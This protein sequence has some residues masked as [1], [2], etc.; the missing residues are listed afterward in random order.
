MHRKKVLLVVMA[1]A[2]LFLLASC[3]N[4]ENVQRVNYALRVAEEG[5]VKEGYLNVEFT[6]IDEE[7]YQVKLDF[8]LGEESFSSTS[9]VKADDIQGSLF[10]LML[11]NPSIAQT[12]GVLSA[13]Q[14]FL[15]PAFLGG[16][17]LSE[18]FEWKQKDEEGETEIIV[19]A[20]ETRFGKEAL[21]VE[22]RKDGKLVA[23]IL[24]EKETSFPLVVDFQD[25]EQL[26]SGQNR[27]YIEAEEV[28]WR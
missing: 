20:S 14:V 23:R 5:G 18:G 7:N 2:M 6:Q 8:A 3:I 17:E 11:S 4:L 26:E 24:F 1:V 12:L 25:P 28:T 9:K 19:P 22:A 13:A 21:W 15:A 16:G 10:P 27:F